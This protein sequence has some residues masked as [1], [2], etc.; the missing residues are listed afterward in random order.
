M[1]VQDGSTERKP[2]VVEAG[3]SIVLTVSLPPSIS[4]SSVPRALAR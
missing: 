3:A 2:S 1:V 4:R